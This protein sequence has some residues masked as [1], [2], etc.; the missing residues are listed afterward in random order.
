MHS[1]PTLTVYLYSSRGT[2]SRSGAISVLRRESAVSELSEEESSGWEPSCRW[3][4]QFVGVIMSRLIELTS[5]SSRG[6]GDWL[7]RI[8]SSIS[9][10]AWVIKF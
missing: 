1:S 7:R 2:H 5:I 8:V 6:T 10:L 4:P 9:S 3:E